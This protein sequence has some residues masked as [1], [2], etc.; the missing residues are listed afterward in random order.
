MLRATCE[1]SS[2]NV[3]CSPPSFHWEPYHSDIDFHIASGLESMKTRGVCWS[4]ASHLSSSSP[5][6]SLSFSVLSLSVP[7]TWILRLRTQE[8][9]R[10]RGYEIGSVHQWH[11]K[12]VVAKDKRSSPVSLERLGGAGSKSTRSCIA[13]LFQVV[14]ISV[15]LSCRVCSCSSTKGKVVSAASWISVLKGSDLATSAEVG[16]SNGL[17][18]LC[19]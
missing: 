8:C 3:I 1:A 10:I 2:S 18:A 17:L 5:S 15:T 16:K 19:A 14:I 4:S 7:L 13:E 9:M 12:K 11:L 6:S